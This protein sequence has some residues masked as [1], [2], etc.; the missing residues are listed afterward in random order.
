M[1][2]TRL[3]F[4]EKEEDTSLLNRFY[5]EMR[6][7]IINNTLTLKEIEN[8]LEIDTFYLEQ[9]LG[10]VTVYGINHLRA[11]LSK[12]I[13]EEMGVAQKTYIKI[14]PFP[15]PVPFSTLRHEAVGKLFSIAGVVSRIESAKPIPTLIM[16][17]CG[18]C[19]EEIEVRPKMGVYT[20]PSKCTLP[21]KSTNFILLKDSYKNEFRDAQRIKVQ[22]LFLTE[23]ERRKAGSINCIVQRDLVNTLLPGDAVHI[24][25]TGIAEESGEDG[26]TIGIKANNIAFLKQ[27]D[28]HN[29]FVFLPDDLER[30]KKLSAQE[31][32]IDILGESIFSEIVGNKVLKKGL[33]LSLVGGSHKKHKRKE[34]HLVVM[35]DPGMGKSKII[36]RASEILPRS[37]YVCGTTTTAGGLGLSMQSSGGGEYVL[38]AGALVL[39][40]LGHCFIDEL[41]KLENPQTLFEAMESQ[42]ITIAKAGMVCAMPT[43]TA[44]IAAA[45]PLFGRYRRDK[46][47]QEN[48]NLSGEFLSRFDL[49]FIMI[50]ELNTKEHCSIARRI[51]GTV[52]ELDSNDSILSVDLAQKYIQYAREQIHPVLSSGA[53]ERIIEFFKT[54]R[55]QKVYNN[56]ILAQPITPRVIDS[57]IRISESVA[58]LHLRE[59]STRSDVD[60]AIEIITM[61]NIP[62][63][64]KKKKEPP[65]TAF[66]QAIQQT[67][68][69]EVSEKDLVRL[70]HSIGLDITTVDK[71]IYKFNNQGIIIKKASNIFKVKI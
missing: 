59:I 7:R 69:K 35:G 21:C 32:I 37:N 67:G 8:T 46:S 24:L 43:R 14:V 45:N 63:T 52:H 53:K 20:K 58:K 38:S 17:M 2:S 60:Q 31:S 62:V 1:N 65:H 39:S 56:R 33:L 10:E 54:I 23:I 34:I 44:V 41:D 15:A 42:E 6:E 16:F 61:E 57:L 12:I 3:Y 30:I 18:K 50:D 13:E 5:Q 27:K 22:E 28:I 4:C 26:Y 48:I 36:R 47:L 64:E 9:K 49:I 11:A 25:G 40:D 51:L 66:M 68:L 71:L 55:T 29:Q 70:G 19:K